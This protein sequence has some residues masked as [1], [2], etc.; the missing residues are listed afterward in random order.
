MHIWTQFETL[1]TYLEETWDHC[2]SSEEQSEKQETVIALYS[3]S[4]LSMRMDWDVQEISLLFFLS[5]GMS[6]HRYTPVFT[7]WCRLR[8]SKLHARIHPV[9]G[10]GSSRVLLP[11]H[12]PPPPPP[13]PETRLPLIQWCDVRSPFVIISVG[14]GRSGQTA[15]DSSLEEYRV[16]GGKRRRVCPGALPW[17]NERR[18][19]FLPRSGR[20]VNLTPTLT[21]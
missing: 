3:I 12:P 6:S 13:H 5:C 8:H 1:W 14:G 20:W 18:R 10:V 4:V 21:C 16:T 19:G 15:A 17:G 7:V 2:I 11:Q 9:V